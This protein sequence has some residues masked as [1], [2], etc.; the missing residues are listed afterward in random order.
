LGLLFP[1]SVK[2]GAAAGLG[3]TPGHG[4]R[5]AVAGSAA[6][7]ELLAFVPSAPRDGKGLSEPAC[8]QGA[9]AA[10]GAVGR[11]TS[12]GGWHTLA[13]AEQ[14]PVE[15]Q[16]LK[17]PSHGSELA[18]S[19]RNRRGHL[20]TGSRGDAAVGCGGGMQQWDAAVGCRM[21]P[22]GLRRGEEGHVQEVLVRWHQIYVGS[23]AGADRPAAH[24]PYILG[25]G[26][27]GGGTEGSLPALGPP[28]PQLSKPCS[29]EGTKLGTSAPLDG[30]A[31]PK[32]ACS[33]AGAA[34]T[35]GAAA[36]ESA[37]RG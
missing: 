36:Q 3:F 5:G 34:G 1:P 19:L 4:G 24:L 13:W 11:G 14:S 27:T 17:R 28:A 25:R 12:R 8:E 6:P 16:G 37:A 2:A 22:G 10:W 30:K 32:G 31:H 26:W 35:R 18:P 9:S 20:G 15:A 23:R 7:R 29:L 33:G 21:V